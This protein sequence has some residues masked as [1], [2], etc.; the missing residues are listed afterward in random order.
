M[1]PDVAAVMLL[2]GS[3]PTAQSIDRLVLVAEDALPA[4]C[5]ANETL[6]STMALTRGV[7]LVRAKITDSSLEA[8]RARIGADIAIRGTWTFGDDGPLSETARIEVATRRAPSR[9]HVER[10]RPGAQLRSALAAIWPQDAPPLAESTSF[11][12]S[13]THALA[14]ACAGD[15]ALASVGPLRSIACSCWNPAMNR[16]SIRCFHHQSHRKGP[17][18]QAPLRTRACGSDPERPSSCRA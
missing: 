6:A 7:R 17:S 9:K 1:R 12:A 11:A 8:A 3:T 15:A 13:S 14:A 18:R 5:A 4:A 10:G 16:R 2:V